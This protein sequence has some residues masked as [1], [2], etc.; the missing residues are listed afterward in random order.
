METNLHKLKE[1][2][3]ES[4]SIDPTLYRQ[5]IGPLMYLVNTRLDIFYAVNASKGD[6]PSCSQTH[7]EILT[8]HS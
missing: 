1:A 6:P 3:A 7:Y 8:R 4:P 2:A 5:M